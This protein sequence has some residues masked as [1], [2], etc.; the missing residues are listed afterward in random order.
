MRTLGNPVGVHAFCSGGLAKT[1][2]PYAERVGAE[3]LQV[4]VSNPRG[5][6]AATGNPL[7]DKAFRE[8]CAARGLPVFVHAP[9]LVNLGS[10]TP[11]TVANSVAA[12]R[13]NLVRGA[14]IGATG[15]VFH[16]GSAVDAGRYAEALGGLGVLL[17]DLLDEA[18][19]LGVR[20][21]VE[22]TAGGGRALAATVPDLGPFFAAVDFHP[23][24]G[25]C[26]DTCHL[27]AAGHDLAAPGGTAAMLD[28]LIA[29]VGADRLALIHANDS[30][31]GCGSKRDRHT[32]IGAG[33]IGV[34]A[35]EE[36]FTHSATDGVP[37][38]VETPDPA[39]DG[40]AHAA[41]LATLRALR[42]KEMAWSS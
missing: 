11:A 25:V 36:L 37:V 29:V 17:R 39:K 38:L 31:D 4:F 28:E 24:L 13:H 7:Q 18:A 22:P 20:L 12:L 42:D 26:L 27:W 3:C 5:W 16:A 41:D 2:L 21:L 8:G 1:A 9:Y 10:P 35:F 40:S 34:A 14:A 30:K 19:A 6:A 23:A 32:N 15:V 33:S